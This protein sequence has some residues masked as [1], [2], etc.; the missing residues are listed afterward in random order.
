MC[1]RDSSVDELE[2]KVNLLVAQAKTRDEVGRKAK[3][4]EET[5]PLINFLNKEVNNVTGIPQ[6]K[7]ALLFPQQGSDKGQRK[8]NKM[9]P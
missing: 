3:A 8:E 4:S 1:I 9:H 5:T 6:V 2:L 7:K